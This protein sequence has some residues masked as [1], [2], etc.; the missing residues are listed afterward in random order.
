MDV[1]APEFELVD[2]RTLD[3]SRVLDLYGAVGWTVYTNDPGTLSLAL[4][5]S[6]TVVVARR[7]EAIVGLAR[8]ISDRATIAYLQDVLVH[9][10]EQRRG[11][12]RTLVEL[13]LQPYAHVRQKVLLTDDEPAQQA[14]YESLG[15][16]LVGGS[17]RAFARFD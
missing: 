5:G 2:G 7:G 10:A 17:L 4:A 11:V 1:S 12:G 9:P 3:L 13:A 6:T 14:F 15:Y 16:S 8:V